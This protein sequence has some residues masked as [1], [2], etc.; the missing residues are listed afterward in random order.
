ME[1]KMADWQVDAAITAS[2][3]GLMT[4]T[5]ISFVAINQRGL[6]KN[7]EAVWKHCMPA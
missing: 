6:S 1:F 4:P 5:G 3:K 7:R 2:Q